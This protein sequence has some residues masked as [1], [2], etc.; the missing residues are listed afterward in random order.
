[1]KFNVS[2]RAPSG[3]ALKEIFTHTDFKNVDAAIK[4]AARYLCFQGNKA[5]IWNTSGSLV[6][7]IEYK[8]GEV[9]KLLGRGFLQSH[10]PQ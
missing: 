4:E 9:H 1:M 5:E 7:T 2:I 3:R 6:H 10:Y 8:R